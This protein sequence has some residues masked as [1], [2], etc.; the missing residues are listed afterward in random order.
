[1]VLHNFSSYKSDILCTQ[2]LLVWTLWESQILIYVE[3]YG[4]V[5]FKNEIVKGEIGKSVRKERNW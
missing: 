4:C 5:W 1:M 3:L 2:P